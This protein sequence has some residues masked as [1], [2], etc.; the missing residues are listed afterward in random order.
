[1]DKA[2]TLDFV[3]QVVRRHEDQVGF[4]VPRRAAGQDA[5][6]HRRFG[7]GRLYR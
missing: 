7:I 5:R 3:V 6:R 4:A 1:M 2:G